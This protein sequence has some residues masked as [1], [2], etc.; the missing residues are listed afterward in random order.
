MSFCSNC[1]TQLADGQ[2]FC[3][4]CGAP[5]GGYAQANA[6]GGGFAD[7][8]NNI[9]NDIQNTNDYSAG[10]EPTDIGANKAMA[11]LSY[12]GILVLIPLLA[13]K[14]SPFARFHANQGLVLFVFRIICGIACGIVSGVLTAIHLGAIGSIITAIVNIG[15]LALAVIGIVNT[16]Q[17]KAKELPVL[18]KIRLLK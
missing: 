3:P 18:G 14:N 10:F 16:A 12:I 8:V 17:G 9:I 5:V 7:G 6:S 11:I 1:G 2:K 13:F 4:N 15:M